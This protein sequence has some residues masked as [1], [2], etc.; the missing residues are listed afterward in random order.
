MLETGPALSRAHFDVKVPGE[1][2]SYRVAVESW[3]ATARVFGKINALYQDD[4]TRL[5]HV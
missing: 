5:V 4:L 1:G 3:R 2:L